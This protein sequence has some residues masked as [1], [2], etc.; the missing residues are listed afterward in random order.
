M[1]IVE[2]VESGWLLVCRIGRGC[3][4][5]GLV[6][7]VGLQDWSGSIVTREWDGL[8]AEGDRRSGAL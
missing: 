4:F 1:C 7:A 5:A 6:A 2:V 3:W 8:A